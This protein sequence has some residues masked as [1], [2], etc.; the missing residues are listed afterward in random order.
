MPNLA[1]KT[2]VVRPGRREANKREKLARIRRAAREV[3]LSKGFEAAT[4]REIAAAAD[5]AFGTLFLYAKDKQDLLLLLFDE[6][7]PA[8]AERG[9]AKVDRDAPFVDQLVAFF[10]E[11]HAFFSPTPR[12]ARDMLR[13]ITFGGGIVATRIWASV[14]GTEREVARLVAQAQAKGLVSSSIAPDLAAHTIF[15]L[16]R[17]EIRFCMADD[18]PDVEASLTRLRRQFEVLYAGLEARPAPGVEEISTSI[19]RKRSY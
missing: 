10:S 1:D 9:F 3:F 12:L 11:F 17:I 16:Y 14:L 6:E 18:K 4:I 2:E 7:L 15:S 5:V 13:E 8:L 19:Y